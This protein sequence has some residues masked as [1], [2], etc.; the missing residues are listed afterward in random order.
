M[1]GMDWLHE[2]SIYHRLCELEDMQHK[3]VQRDDIAAREL[4]LC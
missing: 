1:D 3:L 2:H 4:P